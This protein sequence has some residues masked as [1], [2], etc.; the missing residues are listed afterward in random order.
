META[1]GARRLPRLVIVLGLVSFFNDL[2]SEMVTPL[3]PILLAAVL[4]AGPVALGFIEGLAEAVASGLKLYAGRRSDLWG[5]RRKPFVLAGYFVSNCV[6]PLMGLATGWGG[7]AL[8]RGIDRV[9]K[10]LRTAPRDAMV[11]DATPAALRG[12][13]YGLH[14]AFDNGG[15]M[16]GALLAAACLAWTPLSLPQMILLSAIP[17]FIGVALVAFVVRDAMPQQVPRAPL[18]AVPPLA[19]SLLP[20]LLRRYFL[21]LAVFSLARASE[22]FVVLRGHELGLSVAHLLVLWAAMSFVKALAA[23]FGGNWSDRFGRR[24]IVLWHW[25][26]HGASFALLAGVGSLESLWLAAFLFGACSG[27][28][29]GAERALV[30]DLGS[31]Q[32]RGTA[33]GWYSMTVGLAAIPAGLFFGGLWQAFGAGVA[34]LVAGG[35][36]WL[37]AMLLRLVVLRKG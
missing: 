29:E 30:G 24:R 9:G 5:A 11:A 33:F 31:D 3:I 32:A 35:L 14:R 27:F 7:V 36:A 16:G 10:G 8:L 13:A 26:A 6:R 34:F 20:S 23:W 37:A 28:G 1:P 15:A 12:R 2:A 21:V 18:A 19:W 22:T 4:G 17:G 25:L